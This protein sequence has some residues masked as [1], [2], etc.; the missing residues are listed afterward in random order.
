MQTKNLEIAVGGFMAVGFAA[1]FM[2]AM[3]VSNL[4]L[5][6]AEKGYDVTARFQNIGGLK[7]R[8]PVNIAGVRVGQVTA[9][10]CD[11]KTFEAVVRM[12]ITERYNTL[13]KDTSASIL[14]SGLLGEQYIGLDPGGDSI[15]LKDGDEIRLTQ[16]ALI[17][18]RFIGQF[19][20]SKAQESGNK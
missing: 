11:N 20:Y 6:T 10:Q 15:L 5:L 9:I 14:T 1:L 18:E 19:L 16:S 4:T 3:Q 13:P 8:S 2:L 12:R 7:V 17:L